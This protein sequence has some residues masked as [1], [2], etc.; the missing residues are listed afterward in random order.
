MFVVILLYLFNGLPDLQRFSVVHCILVVIRR[1]AQIQPVTP[2]LGQCVDIRPVPVESRQSKPSAVG[3]G[4]THHLS[5]LI[6]VERSAF[7]LL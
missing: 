1:F 5:F 4:Y 3:C 6:F 7:A 2:D